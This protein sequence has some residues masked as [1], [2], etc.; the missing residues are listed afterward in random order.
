MNYT[1]EEALDFGATLE[2]IA[3]LLGIELEELES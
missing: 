2:D 3:E 1:I